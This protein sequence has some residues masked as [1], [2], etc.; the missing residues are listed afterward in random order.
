MIIAIGLLLAL[1]PLLGVA[2][3]VLTGS[4]FTVDGLFMSLILLAISGVFGTTALFELRNR[5]TGKGEEEPSQPLSPAGSASAGA[6]VQKGLVESVQF[7]ES[8][9]G[10]PNKSIVMLS[11]NST[12]ARMLVLEGDM[13][14]A[15]PVGRRVEVAFRKERDRQVLVDVIY[16]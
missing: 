2:W 12:P 14:N 15:L 11:N 8:N 10:Q 4:P 9:I 6:L 16:S 1:I 3:I 13:R 5:M 7:Y